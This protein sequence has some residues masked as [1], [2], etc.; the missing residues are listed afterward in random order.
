MPTRSPTAK[1]ATLAGLSSFPAC[2]TYIVVATSFTSTDFPAAVLTTTESALIFSSVP[3]T[4]FLSPSASA[5]LATNAA[6]ASRPYS[7]V[8]V[9]VFI[10][11]PAAATQ[12][13]NL[14]LATAIND[15]APLPVSVASAHRVGSR[16]LP[17]LLR[18]LP[19]LGGCSVPSPCAPRR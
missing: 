17:V 12:E 16:F 9:E 1:S 15:D 2:H 18:D 5:T 14:R 8:L 4:C 19:G 6:I 13:S 10:F 7:F 3:T 11:S